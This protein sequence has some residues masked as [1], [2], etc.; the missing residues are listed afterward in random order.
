MKKEFWFANLHLIMIE[1][2]NSV[3]VL[4]YHD[5]K[6]MVMIWESYKTYLN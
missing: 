4:S 6:L 1:T 5:V 3:F 2:N